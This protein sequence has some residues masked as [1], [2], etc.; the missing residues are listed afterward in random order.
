LISLSAILTWEY[1]LVRII[2][3]GP[4]YPIKS[5]RPIISVKENN[6]TSGFKRGISQPK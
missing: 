4:I 2:G 1:A 6:T 3:L 5:Q